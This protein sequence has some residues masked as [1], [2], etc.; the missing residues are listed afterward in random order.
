MAHGSVKWLRVF[1]S[2]TMW[3][4][5]LIYCRL[6]PSR[7][8]WYSF[9]D[10]VRMKSW[11]SFG[12]KEG[13]TNVQILGRAMM[14]LGSYKALLEGR[15]FTNCTSKAATDSRKNYNQIYKYAAQQSF[16]AWLGWMEG[17]PLGWSSGSSHELLVNAIIVTHIQYVK[18]P[19]NLIYKHC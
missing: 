18:K 3:H 14:N 4:L 12:R 15:G 6:A 2:P 11:V 5:S 10:L 1:D 19:E 7:S 8:G 16:S 13:Q 9:T 17:G